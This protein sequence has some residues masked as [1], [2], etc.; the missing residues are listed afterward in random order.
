[1]YP[2]TYEPFLD[3]AF[4]VW[5]LSEE[6]IAVK[7][8]MLLLIL[9]FLLADNPDIVFLFVE[10]GVNDDILFQDILVNM[11]YILEKDVLVFETLHYLQKYHLFVRLQLSH[12][13]T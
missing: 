12:C 5:M 11:K 7:K 10:P 6:L 3:Q 2:H 1:M 9:L 8:G 13:F 4:I